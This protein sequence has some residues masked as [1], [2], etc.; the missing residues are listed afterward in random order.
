MTLEE[1]L[2]L[3]V[4]GFFFPHLSAL[5]LERDLAHAS[6]ASQK[7]RSCAMLEPNKCRERSARLMEQAAQTTDPIEK[8]RLLEIAYGWHRLAVDLAR[9][10]D[11]L[12]G[13]QQNAT[14][15]LRPSP[16]TTY[17]LGG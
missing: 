2:A 17:N 9:L 13:R 7:V 15:C 10:E 1:R 6:S 3:G 5:N 12:S 14:V 11:E 4:A 16:C 8:N